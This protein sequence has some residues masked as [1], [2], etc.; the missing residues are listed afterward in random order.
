VSGNKTRDVPEARARLISWV[1]RPLS[2]AGG[3]VGELVA[4]HL[5]SR[6]PV[7]V[8]TT[9]RVMARRGG[10]EFSLDLRDNVQRTL[11]LTGSYGRPVRDLLLSETRTGDTVVDVGAH[12]GVYA[13]PLAQKLDLLGGGRIYAFEPAPDN[14]SVLRWGA[15]ANGLISM[16]IVPTALGVTRAT[17]ALRNSE[18]FR[19]GDSGVRSL[20][21][22]GEVTSVVE[23]VPYDEWANAEGLTALDIVKIDVEGA[24][25][26]VLMGMVNSVQSARPRCMV[27]EVVPD[28]LERAGRSSRELAELVRDLGYVAD[29]PTIEDI[30]SGQR[31]RLG[32]NVLLRPSGIRSGGG[33]RTRPGFI[34]RTSRTLYRAIRRSP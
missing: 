8:E 1:L 19:E 13:L 34:W 29:G 16:S 5:A 28:H 11:Y 31:G 21:A 6:I 33:F 22:H 24:E 7:S 23:V 14:A 27:V 25:V 17:L 26:D 10:I 32:N 9:S 3:D 12:V 18:D 4:D 2:Q 15:Q 20:H 30:G